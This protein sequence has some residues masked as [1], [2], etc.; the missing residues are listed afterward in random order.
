[1]KDLLA[2]LQGDDDDEAGGW[3]SLEQLEKELATLDS[4]VSAAP[5]AASSQP[6]SAASLVVSSQPA[7]V[8]TEAPVDAWT[9][10]LQKFAATNLEQEFLEADSARKQAVKPPPGLDFSQ[11]EDYDVQETAKVAPP[12]GMGPG[13]LNIL[14]Q[15]ANK[16]MQQSREDLTPPPMPP[17]VG[18]PPPFTPQNS[19][20][21]GADGNVIPPTPPPSALPTPAVPDRSVFPMSAGVPPLPPAIPVG[22]AVPPPRPPGR[23]WEAHPPPPPLPQRMLYCNAHPQAPPIHAQQLSSRYMSAR[24]IS[25][26]IHSILKPLLQSGTTEY[27]YDVQYHLR[28]S[29]AAGG[30]KTPKKNLEKESASREKKAKQWSNQHATL[31]HVAKANVTRPRAL[32]AQ[33]VASTGGSDTENKQRASLWKARIYCDQAYQAY[34]A[35]VDGWKTG[36]A[37]P[38]RYVRLFKCLGLTPVPDDSSKFTSDQTALE[39]LLKLDKGRVLLARILEQALLPPNAMQALLPVI[40]QVLC[41]STPEGVDDRIFVALAR[42]VQTLPSLSGD[43]IVECVQVIEANSKSALSSTCRMQCVHALLS[44]GTAMSASDPSFT[45]KWSETEASFM[46]LLT[47]I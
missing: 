26:V 27:D 2:D 37:V 34:F 16:V 22:V 24:D 45:P 4:G 14:A 33:P 9:L 29:G 38:A 36:G 39:L 5:V 21:L 6:F 43:I 44:R 8:T 17:R 23:A 30:G 12:P 10:S 15:A 47:G 35:V 28:R 1:M 41:T 20:T 13:E 11:A 40:M 19:I 46:K 42:I 7:A 3:L 31:G 18:K 25:Y 32:I